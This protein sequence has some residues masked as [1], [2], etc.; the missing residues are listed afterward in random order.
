MELGGLFET[1]R[2]L[3]V[4]LV[5]G[6]GFFLFFLV[7]ALLVFAVILLGGVVITSVSM[8]VLYVLPTVRYRFVSLTER[9]SG[10][11][12][13]SLFDWRFVSVYV[14]AVAS[15]GVGLV[16][17]A[18]VFA[19][20]VGTLVDI[21][22]SVQS[23]RNSLVLGAVSVVAV[24]LAI[25]SHAVTTRGLRAVVEWMVFLCFAAVLTVLSVSVVPR[26]TVRLIRFFF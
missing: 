16:F 9:V 1:L 14:L 25:L 8:P 26:Y 2:E 22:P 11:E 24:V 19:V 21:S 23:T 6:L 4:L 13:N 12:V 5:G 10:R 20:T 15:F 3:L 7:V 17:A 18:V